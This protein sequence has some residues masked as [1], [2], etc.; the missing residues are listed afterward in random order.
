MTDYLVRASALRGIRPTVEALG[1][2]ADAVLRRADLIETEQDPDAWFSYRS[3]LLLLEKELLEEV[4][5]D[6]AQCYIRK[7][8]GS[9]T[10]LADMLCYSDLSVF[11]NAFRQ[12]HGISPREWKSQHAMR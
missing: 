12:H 4:R 8:N 11:S 10:I 3:F 9:L 7:S 1:G 5:F 2:D 6:I